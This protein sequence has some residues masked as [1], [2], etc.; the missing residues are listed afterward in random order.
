MSELTKFIIGPIQWLQSAQKKQ[1]VFVANRA[2]EIMET[3]PWINGDISNASK[4]LQ[5]LA[6]EGCPSKVSR[7]PGC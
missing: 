2:A 3:R 5:I 6:Q 4:T 7:I 1:Q